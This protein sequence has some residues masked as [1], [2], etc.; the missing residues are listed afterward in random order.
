MFGSNSAC[1]VIYYGFGSQANKASYLYR[2]FQF[3]MTE[4]HELDT[5][6]NQFSGPRTDGWRYYRSCQGPYRYFK[7][8][9]VLPCNVDA[10]NFL[11]QRSDNFRRWMNDQ[12]NGQLLMWAIDIKHFDLVKEILS[13][14]K[15]TATIEKDKNKITELH[16]A[17]WRQAPKELI[18]TLLDIYPRATEHTDELGN[19]PLHVI[20]EVLFQPEKTFELN[21]RFPWVDDVKWT[22]EDANEI[23]SSVLQ[24]NKNALTIQDE[25]GDTPL[26]IARRS[27]T[28]LDGIIQILELNTMAG[29]QL[30]CEHQ[31]PLLNNAQHRHR[32]PSRRVGE[33]ERSMETVSVKGEE[34]RPVLVYSRSANEWVAGKIVE[35]LEGGVVYVHYGV[36]EN[37]CGEY[38]HLSSEHIKI[39]SVP[40]KKRIR[41]QPT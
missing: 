30:G 31:T 33:R 18:R 9:Y 27:V 24:Q 41:H 6:L 2:C 8:D 15:H 23:M 28:P 5:L 10:L 25:D 34:R 7:S 22:P 4:C 35:I 39:G 32:S 16:L 40:A 37:W 19:T 20:V 12:Y 3:S 26:A 11:Y 38:M 1:S 17:L 36:G 14:D 21:S 13:D 29:T